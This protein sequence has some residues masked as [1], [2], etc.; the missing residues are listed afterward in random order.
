MLQLR[1]ICQ[2]R[3]RRCL[4]YFSSAFN[5]LANQGLPNVPATSIQN[6]AESKLL[7]LDVFVNQDH[8]QMDFVDKLVKLR[9]QKDCTAVPLLPNLVVKQLLDYTGPQ[10]AILALQNPL[11]YGIFI[12]QFAGCHLIDLLMHNGSHREAAQVAA[13][14]IER[15]LCNNELIASLAIQSFHAYLQKFEPKVAEKD[16][17]STEVEKVRVKFVRNRNEAESI[18]TEEQVMGEALLK[19]AANAALKDFSENVSLLGYALTGNLVEAEKVLSTSKDNLYKDILEVARKVI[20]ALSTEKPAELL[21]QLDHAITDSKR[22]ESLDDLLIHRVKRSAAS[23]EPQ[24]MSDYTKSYKDWEANFQKAV[25]AKLKVQDID[26]RVE[27]IETTLSELETRRQ[28]LWYFENKEDIDMQIFKKQK[29][30]PKRWFGKKK[31]P[32]AVDA[33]YVPPEISRGN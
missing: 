22:S 8:R 2:Q 13:M 21:N 27:E 25:Q 15:N 11:Q 24:L 10:E 31:K 17:Q 16:E 18:K 6:A 19:L 23:L 30:Y 12:D 3:N 28:R 33:F 4:S 20:D 1:V 7:D 14:L 5:N 26:K 9:K 29:H 32:K